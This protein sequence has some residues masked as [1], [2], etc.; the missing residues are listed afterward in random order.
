LGGD[1]FP[2]NIFVK[3]GAGVREI[4]DLIFILTFA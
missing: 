2:D 4:R 1:A 3:R